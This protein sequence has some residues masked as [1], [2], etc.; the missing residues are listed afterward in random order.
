MCICFE[1]VLERDL[2]KGEAVGV[3]KLSRGDRAKKERVNNK[4]WDVEYVQKC[5]FRFGKVLE[6]EIDVG[7][8]EDRRDS[9]ENG[10]GY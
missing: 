8:D 4:E 5:M 10:M 1:K 3:R 2:K 9:V 6:D 7:K